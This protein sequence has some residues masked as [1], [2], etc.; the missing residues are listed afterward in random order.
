MEI[1]KTVCSFLGI[2]YFPVVAV[3]TWTAFRDR[4]LKK[5]VKKLEQVTRSQELL[6]SA[7]LYEVYE[8]H[9]DYR[10]RVLGDWR[11]S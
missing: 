7:T 10:K 5:R 2:L 11:Q 1:L 6:H 4:R 3:G 8:D 9:P